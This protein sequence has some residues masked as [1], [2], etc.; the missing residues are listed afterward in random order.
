MSVHVVSVRWS[1][2]CF[3]C[4]LHP[5]VRS[6]SAHASKTVV[7]TFVS[8]RLDYCN[9]LVFGITDNL[10]RPLQAIQNA[11]AY[12]VISTWRCE[13]ITAVLQQLHWLPICQQIQFMLA[14]LV[15]KVLN[16]LALHVIDD[17]PLIATTGRRHYL[18]SSDN[19]TCAIIST[20]SLHAFA[21]AGPR[22]WNSLPIHI[23]QPVLT[24]DSFFRQLK[25]YFIVWAQGTS[26]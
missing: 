23:C 15:Y 7:H 26:A 8:S 10:L 16:N 14:V 11:A 3:L 18:S 9:S 20:N 5:V 1:A 4:Q 17:C 19:V 13:H 6:L 25:I 12:L 22:L 24:L 21:A 2:Y